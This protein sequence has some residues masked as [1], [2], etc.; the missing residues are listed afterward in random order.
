M[1]RSSLA[2]PA[3]RLGGHILDWGIWFG[4]GLFGT[5]TGNP[6]TLGLAITLALLVQ[7]FLWN[8]G[9]SLGKMF[10]SMKVVYKDTG[11]TVGF[12]G[13]LLRETIGKVISGILGGLGYFWILWDKERQGLHDKFI[14]SIVIVDER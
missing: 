2:S 7:S 9:T 1:N 5:S 3:R 4:I 13:M 12:F 14:S 11:H 8:K 10:L 6:N